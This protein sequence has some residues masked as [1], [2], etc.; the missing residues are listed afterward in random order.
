MASDEQN[1]SDPLPYVQV[2]RAV[3]PKAMMVA[4]RIGTSTQH[5]L[6]S[7]IGFW[8]MCGDPRD[9]ERLL[10]E[11][12]REVVLE[13][14]VVQ[15]RFR[16]ASG[17]EV[18]PDELVDMGL[19]EPKG[20]DSFRV[21]GMSRYFT[22]IASRLEARERA[23]K[24]GIASAEA[25]RA[26]TGS[27]QPR[28]MSESGSEHVREDVREMFG[29][30]SASSSGDVPAALD[31]PATPPNPA[32]SGQRSAVKGHLLEAPAARSSDGS[33]DA[34]WVWA[35]SARRAAGHPGEH[36]P[37]D[38]SGWWSGVL[39]EL[40]GEHSRIERAFEHFLAD[41]HWR[42]EGCPFAAFK[43]QWAKY[44]SEHYGRREEPKTAVPQI[45]TRER[46]ACAAC[47]AGAEAELA[48]VLLC[49]DGCWREASAWAQAQS[50]GEP[51]KADVASWA[52]ERRGAA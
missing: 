47:G 3:K 20:Q 39:M 14:A 49:Y 33:A 12:K 52:R 23:R 7:L 18:D 38:L 36:P 11:G 43:K 13:R 8:E 40:A 4:G 10:Q 46:K 22:P 16:I 35:N 25:R 37:R 21:R 28:K 42:A 45:I 50:P 27:A 44:A 2:D 34:F 48:G 41:P 19:L 30:S 15:R 24:A 17:H 29:G 51:W 5:A 32:V 31:V 6:G 1:D 26:K 9:I